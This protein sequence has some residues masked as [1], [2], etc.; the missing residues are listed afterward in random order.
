MVV[1][2]SGTPELIEITSNDEE[3]DD[4][5]KG[6]PE[7]EPVEKEIEEEEPKEDPRED[8]EIG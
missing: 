2:L 5:L 7:E 4:Q 8:P 3:P 6:D 1:D